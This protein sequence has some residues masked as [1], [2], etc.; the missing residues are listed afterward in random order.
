VL[1]PH[2]A[3]VLK[4]RAPGSHPGESLL[5]CRRSSSAVALCGDTATMAADVT[6]AV[7]G[8]AGA[9]VGGGLT[10]LSTCVA[11]RADEREVR[12]PSSAL[13]AAWRGMRW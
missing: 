10:A 4:A 2:G 5:A 11:V 12:Q 6:S 13:P 8:L 3:P 7:I 1:E 9:L